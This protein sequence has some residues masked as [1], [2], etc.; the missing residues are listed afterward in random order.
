MSKELNKEIVRLTLENERIKKTSKQRFQKN[1]KL[2]SEMKYLNI[3]NGRIEVIKNFLQ[4]QG[5]ESK[6]DRGTY[7]VSFTVINAI[8]TLKNKAKITIK[9]EVEGIYSV[10]IDGK[11]QTKEVRYGLCWL[12]HNETH[13]R[14]E[15]IHFY[16][17]E[18]FILLE[19]KRP[20]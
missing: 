10:K 17:T 7:S 14:W 3:Q 9:P 8:K 6:H 11:W 16:N 18:E 5:F 20:H 2:E 4:E 12:F 19:P 1:K 15:G 13:N